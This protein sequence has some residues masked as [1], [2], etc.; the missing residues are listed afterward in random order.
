MSINIKQYHIKVIDSFNFHYNLIGKYELRINEI[1]DLLKKG[2]PISQTKYLQTQLEYL[3]HL[4]SGA[5]NNSELGF[6]MLD[7]KKI[8]DRYIE[9]FDQPILVNFRTKKKKNLDQELGLIREY[10]TILSKYSIYLNFI[11]PKIEDEYNDIEQCPECKCKKFETYDDRIVCMECSYETKKITSNSSFKDTDRVNAGAKYKYIKVENFEECIQDY[12]GQPNLNITKSVF[13]NL[14][15]KLDDHHIL[16]GNSK[17]ERRERFN[18][19]SIDHI[20]RFLRITKC[21]KFYNNANYIWSEM[22]GKPSPNI[23]KYESA[24]V[25]DIY[26][27]LTP[28]EK[29][30]RSSFLNLNYV[31][32]QLLRRHKSGVKMIFFKLLKPDRMAQHNRICERV[33]DRL[34]WTFSAL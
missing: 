29:E 25:D 9:I 33:F 1:S 19:V 3:K 5:N 18:D 12:Q 23:R 10:F 20:R 22:T 28:E 7:T 8:L 32:C 16:I 15:K 11:I 2:I 13:D 14:E 31:L 26:D 34:S 17:T 30:G 27:I 4:H 6:Y 24:L 21:S